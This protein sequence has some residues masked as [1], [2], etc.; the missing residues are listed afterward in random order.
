MY[1]VQ[2]SIVFYLFLKELFLPTC[3]YSAVGLKSSQDLNVN[4][5]NHEKKALTVMSTISQISFNKNAQPS[6]ISNIHTSH[7]N[8]C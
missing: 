2:V 1:T 8:T 4:I 7:M 6:P 3:K 5:Y